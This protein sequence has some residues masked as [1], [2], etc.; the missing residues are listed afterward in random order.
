MC[1]WY[2]VNFTNKT[3]FVGPERVLYMYKTNESF[4]R[5]M[6]IIKLIIQLLL[7]SF[8]LI[9]NWLYFTTSINFLLVFY[10]YILWVGKRDECI[11][12]GIG[13]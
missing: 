9:I 3:H 5:E 6:K 8:T 10:F 2:A 11:A 13:T 4:I 12:V 7:T 1:A